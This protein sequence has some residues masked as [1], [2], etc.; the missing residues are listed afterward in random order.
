[1]LVLASRCF[2]SGATTILDVDPTELIAVIPLKQR[3][4]HNFIKPFSGYKEVSSLIRLAALS[5]SGLLP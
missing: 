4:S 5:A 3:D 2:L 1:V